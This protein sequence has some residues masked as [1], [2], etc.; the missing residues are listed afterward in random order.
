MRRPDR[1]GDRL[2][3]SGDLAK[4]GYCERKTRYERLLGDRAT[5]E[6]VL[7]QVRGQDTHSSLYREGIELARAP[8]RQECC[9]ASKVL[10]ESSWTDQLRSF[11]DD[12]MRHAAIG[13][14]LILRYYAVSPAM[15]RMLDRWPAAFQALRP[16]LIALAF[17]AFTAVRCVRL[18]R[19]RGMNA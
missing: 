6:Q 4:L 9:V 1:R 14:L 16:A 7:A 13:R 10:G 15:C 3:R 19:A 8:R 18:A 17:L 2:V 12:V 11:R 5:A